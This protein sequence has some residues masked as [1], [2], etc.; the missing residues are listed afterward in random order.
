VPVLIGLWMALAG[1]ADAFGTVERTGFVVRNRRPAE[2][3]PLPRRLRRLLERDRYRA[4]VAIDDGTTDTVVAWKT[5]ER[6]AV[7][8][9]ARATVRAT[10]ALGHVRRAAPVGHRLVE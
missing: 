1:A 4:Y 7:P 8:Q 9:G 5:S 2:I 6:N 10:W 3:S